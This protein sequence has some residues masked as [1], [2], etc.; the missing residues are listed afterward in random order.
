V[1]VATPIATF[2]FAGLL[3]RE[4]EPSRRRKYLVPILVYVLAITLLFLTAFGYDIRHRSL[5]PL[6]AIGALLFCLSDGV[7][8]W[9]RFARPF[10]AAQ[11]VILTTYYSA[12]ILI[13]F[14][15]IWLISRPAG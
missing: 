6:F 2:C 9:N 12:Q 4:M 13:T 11:F 14:K 10:H 7:L 3:L 8:A 15:A 1:L 5:P